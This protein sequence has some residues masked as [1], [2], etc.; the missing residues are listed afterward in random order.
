MSLSKLHAAFMGLSVLG[1]VILA[2]GVTIN[3]D[4]YWF[5]ANIVMAGIFASSAAV[6]YAT[7]RQDRRGRD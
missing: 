5:M 7:L 4:S 6:F 2:I 1:V 3:N